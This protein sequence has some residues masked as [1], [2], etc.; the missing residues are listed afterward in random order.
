VQDPW[1]GFGG[2]WLQLGV[3]AGV[4]VVCGALATL[5]FRRQ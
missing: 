3:L 1:L 5:A 2:N 4:T